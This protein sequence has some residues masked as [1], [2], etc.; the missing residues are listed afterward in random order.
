[1]QQAQAR[2]RLS[3]DRVL[4]TA[5]ALILLLGSQLPVATYLSPAPASDTP[6]GS[7]AER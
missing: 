4:F 3:P 7:S 6:S 5:A 1:M 2:T